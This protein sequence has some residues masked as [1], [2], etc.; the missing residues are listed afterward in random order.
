MVMVMD[1]VMDMDT[2]TIMN[3]KLMEPV[4]TII[5]GLVVIQPKVFEDSRG[6]FYEPYNKQVLAD[7]GINDDFVQDNQ[8]LSQKDV[9]R[10]LHFQNPPFA[11]AK[12][13]RVI[14][15]AVWDVVVDIRKSSPTYGDYYGIE[16]S[17]KNKTIL[18]IPEGF[19]HG[20]K[21][22]EDNTVFLYKCSRYYNKPSEDS[23]LWSD[24][25]IG[26]EWDIENPVL[27]DKDRKGKL[28]KEF[29][30]QF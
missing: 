12:M 17:A 2:A 9:V 26:I 5:K 8:S 20:F 19:A 1:T 30:S 18:Y 7:M 22:L 13:V 21:T 27:S 11:Q 29:K 24:P 4:D 23:I 15:G 14:Q 10:G 16:L 25:D 3:H 6:Y 28:F